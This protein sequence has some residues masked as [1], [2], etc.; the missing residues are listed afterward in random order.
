MT[1]QQYK[2]RLEQLDEGKAEIYKG[3]RELILAIIEKMQYN[4]DTR[5]LKQSLV[6]DYL[7]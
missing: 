4:E 2:T 5:K 7:D 1:L 6:D 3:E